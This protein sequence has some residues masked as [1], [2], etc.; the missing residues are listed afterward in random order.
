MLAWIV[1]DIEYFGEDT[2]KDQSNIDL[3]ILIKALIVCQ[4]TLIFGTFITILKTKFTHVMIVA[5]SIRYA[6]FGVW[7]HE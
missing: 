6:I 7:L 2:L 4:V 1:I 3:K 5:H